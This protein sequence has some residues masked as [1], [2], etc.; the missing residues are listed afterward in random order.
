MSETLEQLYEAYEDAVARHME[1]I[2]LIRAAD[3]IASGLQNSEDGSLIEEFRSRLD[4]NL[5]LATSMNL[6]DL[7]YNLPELDRPES[8]T[9]L[10]VE[11]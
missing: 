3:S 7:V 2:L 5:D 1:M 10:S 6:N 11:R 9:P 4:D 8:I